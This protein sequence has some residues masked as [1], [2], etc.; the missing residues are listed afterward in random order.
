MVTSVSS[1]RARV[2]S[3]CA[4]QAHE[5][6]AEEDQETSH[7]PLTAPQH[8]PTVVAE[9]IFREKLDQGCKRQQTGRDGVHGANQKESDL[10]LWAV[11]GMSREADGLADR[12][13][14]SY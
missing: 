7:H 9:E 1:L 10:R 13:P 3:P 6:R 4:N 12:S 11:E 8:L 5:K 14:T 2:S